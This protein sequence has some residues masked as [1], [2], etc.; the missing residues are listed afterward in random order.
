MSFSFQLFLMLS[1]VSFYLFNLAVDQG[2]ASAYW[3]FDEVEFGV[4]PVEATTSLVMQM[5]LIGASQKHVEKLRL[6]G[7]VRSKPP[8]NIG[9]N[10]VLFADL[11]Q[12]I[13]RLVVMLSQQLFLALIFHFLLSAKDL[14][15]FGFRL[16]K[17][18]IS[19]L[20]LEDSELKALRLKQAAV[21]LADVSFERLHS[22]LDPVR[23]LL[24][25]VVHGLNLFSFYF[26]DLAVVHA[27]EVPLVFFR[28][29]VGA[30]VPGVAE[31]R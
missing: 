27:Q 24:E 1:C 21:P 26:V 28:F 13:H 6:V 7:L 10:L 22:F 18:S 12:G 4:G 11:L 30:V 23:R 3:F 25:E 20:L 2:L 15:H 29:R 5:W 14:L 8:E 19:P 16:L 17:I 31:V 9:S